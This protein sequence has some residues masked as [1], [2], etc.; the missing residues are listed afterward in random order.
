MKGGKNPG[1]NLNIVVG[2]SRVTTLEEATAMS[3]V[4]G[5]T[6]GVAGKGAGSPK[7]NGF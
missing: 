6:P 4:V 3:R 7:A 2:G 1:G 5:V